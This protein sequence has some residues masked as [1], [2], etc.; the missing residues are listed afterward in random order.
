[1]PETR[2]QHII[3]QLKQAYIAW[4]GH[5]PDQVV[6]LKPSGS[7]RKYY[8]VA[9]G[10]DTYIGVYHE[11]LAE[12]KAFFDFSLHFQKLGLPV[13]GLLYYD[14]RSPYY[15]L[16]DLGDNILFE[17]L[18]NRE[19]S[20]L[21]D[22]LLFIYRET[23][24]QLVR[25]Q[26]EAHDGFPYGSCY[27][28]A[29]FDQVAIRW[30]LDYFKYYFL[31]LS[32]A[33]FH[34]NKLEEEFYRLS[35][36]LANSPYQYFM[37]RDFQSRNVLLRDN[38]PFFID[39]QG[40]RKGP[41]LYD[42][43]SLL[44]QARARITEVDRESL[45]RFYTDEISKRIPVDD[46]GFRDEFRVSALV[47][48]MQTLGTYG[49]RGFYERKPHFMQSMAL[50][51]QNLKYLL[52]DPGFPFGLPHL[53]EVIESIP[54]IQF[55]EQAATKPETLQVKIMSFSY[56]KGVPADASDHGGGFVFDC[57][58]LP[59]PGRYDQYKAYTGFDE[60][61]VEFFRDKDDMHGF[62]NNTKAILSKAVE[63]YLQR[64]FKHLS[65]FFG[66]TGGQHRSVYATRIIAAWL[67]ENYPVQLN[68]LHREL[69][70]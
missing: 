18:I 8:R 30:D 48:V 41:V 43:A 49:F 46:E 60:Q 33:P 69:T 5:F 31:K 21:P 28:V 35:S 17:E 57:R 38:K 26:L 20:P 67:E 16:E 34:E 40:G 62:L 29:V 44:F 2:F 47:R 45:F 6:P 25:F 50:S 22:A 14:Y 53:K 54:A 1:M 32:N 7:A 51:Y 66:C 39:Y 23:I 27:P 52:Q 70:S 24:K 68:I 64:D 3:L 61:V 55:D 59:N 56:K 9:K 37:Y 11:S 65:V 4:R 15:F 13:P 19:D 58:F 63:N 10:Q 36:F 42:L 12:N